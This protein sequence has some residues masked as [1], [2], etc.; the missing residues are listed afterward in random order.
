MTVATGK[1]PVL[2]HRWK[3]LGIN[4]Q[5]KHRV[6]VSIRILQGALKNYPVLVIPKD[7]TAFYAS[8]NDVVHRSRCVY[9]GFSRHESLMTYL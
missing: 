5:A 2:S 1:L 3:W 4:A 6:F 8:D 9:S 7:D